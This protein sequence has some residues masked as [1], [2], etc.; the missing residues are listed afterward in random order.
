MELRIFVEPQQGASYEQ[1][2]A[3][4]RHAEAEGF[5]AFFRSDHWLRIGPGDGLP[6]PTDSWVTLGA[7]A[8]ETTTIRLGTMVSSATFRW[9]GI[10]AATVAQVDA[11]SGGRVELGLG[12]GWYEQEH[13]AHGVPFPPLGERFD[14]LEEQLAIVTG[15][16]ETPEGGVYSFTGRHYTVVDTPA[17]PKPVQ[18]PRP[19]VIVGGKGPRRTPALAARFADECNSSFLGLDEFGMLAQRVRVACEAESRDPTTMTMSASLTLCCGAS[20]AEVERRATAIGRKPAELRRNA[21]AGTPGELIET[22]GGFA[23]AGA[24]RAYLQVLDMNDLDHL[25]LVAAEVM[26]HV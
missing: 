17:L 2:L 4:A 15:M 23:G 10:L 12:T 1:Q 9:P 21:L 19:P 13:A 26:P 7:I 14:R 6:G 22:L 5:G 11:M 16:W 18:R 24:G 3:V 25:S 8:R 20:E